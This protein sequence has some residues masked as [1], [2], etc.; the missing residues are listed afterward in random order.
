MV[1][2]VREQKAARYRDM[3][4][5]RLEPIPGKEDDP[6]WEWSKITPQK[7][8]VNARNEDE[9]RLK[10]HFE[11]LLMKPRFGEKKVPSPPWQISELTLCVCDPAQHV[12][13]DQIL[14]ESGDVIDIDGWTEL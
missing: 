3:D 13:D 14:L 2:L 8:W 11:S 6:S 10:V 12:N 4:T 9:A 1:I 7:V 5:Y